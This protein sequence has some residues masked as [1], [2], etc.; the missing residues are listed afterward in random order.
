MIK[1]KNNIHHH[2]GIHQFISLWQYLAYS[3]PYLS[4]V[5]ETFDYILRES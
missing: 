4:L 1:T 5:Y 2:T 3:F